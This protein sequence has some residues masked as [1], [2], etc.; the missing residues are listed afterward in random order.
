MDLP[1][2]LILK[3][4]ARGWSKEAIAAHLQVSYHSVCRWARG[5]GGITPGN[6]RRLHELAQQQDEA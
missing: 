1:H 2:T 5:K 3:L 6:H 4:K